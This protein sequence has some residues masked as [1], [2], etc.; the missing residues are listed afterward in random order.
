MRADPNNLPTPIAEVDPEDGRFVH[1]SM[2][3]GVLSVC[4]LGYPMG[5]PIVQVRNRKMTGAER[6]ADGF[7]RYEHPYMVRGVEYHLCVDFEL[8]DDLS[9]KRLVGGHHW[10]T[11]ERADTR[12]RNAPSDTTYT[13]LVMACQQAAAVAYGMNRD[14]WLTARVQHLDD[15]IKHAREQRAKLLTEARQ[16]HRDEQELAKSRDILIRV[17]D[18]VREYPVA[19]HYPMHNAPEQRPVLHT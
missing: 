4:F 17:A 14:G 10:S 5:K 16:L 13:Q 8:L 7:N 15:R 11:V 2:P 18:P 19:P 3:G 9:W 12:N 1:V 6:R